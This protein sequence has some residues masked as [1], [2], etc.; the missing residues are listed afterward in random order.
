MAFR[1]FFDRFV[2]FFRNALRVF[3][4]AFSSRFCNNSIKAYVSISGLF[5]KSRRRFNVFDTMAFRFDLY[6]MLRSY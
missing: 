1:S 5:M 2:S 4:Y 6:R 3:I